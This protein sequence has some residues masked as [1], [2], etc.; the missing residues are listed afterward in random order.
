M[1]VTALESKTAFMIYVTLES[2]YDNYL[3]INMKELKYMV[4]SYIWLSNL[5]LNNDTAKLKVTK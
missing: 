4:L 2:N 1:F 3:N 5:S